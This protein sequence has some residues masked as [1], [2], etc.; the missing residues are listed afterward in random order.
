MKLLLLIFLLINYTFCYSQDNERGLKQVEWKNAIEHETQNGELI[1]EKKNCNGFLY[2]L[3]LDLDAIQY[4]KD[5]LLSEYSFADSTEVFIK[6][7]DSDLKSPDN[8][9]TT[10]EERKDII[11]YFWFSHHACHTY[12][13]IDLFTLDIS[14][15]KLYM[16]EQTGDT[17]K[18]EHKFKIIEEV[19]FNR[20][21]FEKYKTCITL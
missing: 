7:I 14:N 1:S 2:D 11:V 3:I 17:V 8:Q 4:K 10:L 20:S 9:R 12:I 13:E 6:G 18:G 19:A 15:E 5:S 21:L 16:S